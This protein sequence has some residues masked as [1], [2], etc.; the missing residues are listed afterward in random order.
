MD[1]NK[2]RICEVAIAAY[3][4]VVEITLKLLVQYAP[5]QGGTSIALRLSVCMSVSVTELP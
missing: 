1:Y 2:S 5:V 3:A 4:V